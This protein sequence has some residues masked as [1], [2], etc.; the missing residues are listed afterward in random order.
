MSHRL[1]AVV[2]ALALGF[3]TNACSGGDDAATTAP[4]DSTTATVT[5]TFTSAD[6]LPTDRVGQV[7]VGLDGTV[8]VAVEGD[9][10]RSDSALRYETFARFDGEGWVDVGT[11]DLV[12]LDGDPE[13]NSPVVFGMDISGGPDGSLWVVN[14]GFDSTGDIYLYNGVEWLSPTNDRSLATGDAALDGSLWTIGLPAS[15]DIGLYRV[16]GQTVTLQ[17]DPDGGIGCVLC[18]DYDVDA[19]GLLWMY[20]GTISSFDG[21]AWTTLEGEY[22]ELDGIGTDSTEGRWALGADGTH[23]VLRRTAEG[24]EIVRITGGEVTTMPVA[25]SRVAYPLDAGTAFAGGAD[26]RLW[27]AIESV[28]LSSIDVDTGT[29]TQYGLDDGLPTLELL[30]IAAHPDGTI[31]VATAAGITRIVPES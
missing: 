3:G 15:G 20:S 19:D 2:M 23:W 17:P 14:T 12:A 5:D 26:G 13:P 28:G 8:W 9:L 16:E 4:A 18:V 29:V 22:P 7:V 10:V 11:P 6:G 25:D 21:A 1:A 27:L 30:D 24:V 31:W